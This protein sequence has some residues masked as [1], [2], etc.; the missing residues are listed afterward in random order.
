MMEVNPSHADAA[1][2]SRAASATT[3][4]APLESLSIGGL[5][6]SAPLPP[7]HPPALPAA[8]ASGLAFIAETPASLATASVMPVEAAADD[9]VERPRRVWLPVGLFIATCVSTFWV[10]TSEWDFLTTFSEPLAMLRDHWWRGLVYSTAVL[11]ILMA[12]EMGH[13]LQAVRYR[14]PASL[15]YFIPM[16]IT[17]FGTMGAVIALGG[18]QANRRQ[19]F[20][21]G[22]TGPLAGLVIAV[23]L[24]C[25]GLATATALP[26]STDASLGGYF[27]SPIIFQIIEWFVRPIDPPNT[28]LIYY[29][30]PLVMAGW[31]GMFVT[32]LNMVPVGQLDGGHVAYALF[33]KRAHWLARAV[34]LATVVFIVAT[35]QYGWTLIVGLVALLGIHHPSTADDRVELGFT[36]TVLGWLSLS[37]P[38]LCLTPFPIVVV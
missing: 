8:D 37:I 19:L 31:I 16:P 7:V 13:F 4:G 2:Q 36:R 11:T 9:F 15:P 34:L 24:T 20:D 3:S 29:S 14:V 1:G 10:G 25:W 32:G 30:N 26:A 28:R 12:H 22:L 5:A 33:G 6:T 35:G 17:P 23:P 27:G 38:I 18:S 21:I